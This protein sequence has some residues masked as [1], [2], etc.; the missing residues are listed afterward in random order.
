MLARARSTKV[1]SR[2][3]ATVIAAMALLA[4][5]GWARTPRP[6]QR[7]QRTRL[8]TPTSFSISAYCRGRTTAAGTKVGANVVAADKAVF[9]MGTVLR[10]AGLG[11]RY[12][13]TYTVLDTGP[14]VRGRRLDIYLR[15]CREAVRFGRRSGRVSAVR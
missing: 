12:N 7:P 3:I 8:V 5:D 11:R 15:N 9:P 14:R 2:L 6:R 1:Q 10:L 4:A 13:G